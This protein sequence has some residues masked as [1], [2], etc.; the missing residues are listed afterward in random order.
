MLRNTLIK[1]VTR[2]RLAYNQLT[3]WKNYGLVATF[4]VLK[5]FVE[6]YLLTYTNEHQLLLG[7]GF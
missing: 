6:L 3:K 7:K 5:R 4:V 2:L 1:V